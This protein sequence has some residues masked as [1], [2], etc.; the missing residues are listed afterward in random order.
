[1]VKQS[2]LLFFLFFFSMRINAQ[3]DANTQVLQDV[4]H[5]FSSGGGGKT[6]T[7]A[8][9]H[10]KEATVGSPYLFNT[11]VKGSVITGKGTLVNDSSYL[12]NFNKMTSSLLVLQNRKSYIE[13]YMDNIK[14]FVLADPSGKENTYERI[15]GIQQGIFCKVLADGAICGAYKLVT[16]KFEK[17]NYHT[18][19]L[20]ETG[21]PYDEYVDENQ[22]FLVF[23]N[24]AYRKIPELKIK[25]LSKLLEGQSPKGQAW[26]S[27][28]KNDTV[29]EDFLTALVRYINE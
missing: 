1:M 4:F 11:W 13:L 10:T 5:D 27:A 17:S 25:A 12:Y 29:N 26:L 6:F 3:S 22:Y 28:H 19:G 14:S 23:S 18:D 15:P 20:V 7:G 8:E 9:F 21:N 2:M 16:T 24:S